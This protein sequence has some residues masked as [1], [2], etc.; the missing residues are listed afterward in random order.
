MQ[1]P[2]HT[3]LLTNEQHTVIDGGIWRWISLALALGWIATTLLL[4]RNRRRTASEQTIQRPKSAPLQPLKKAVSAACASGDAHRTKNALLDWARA[5]W[6][7][8]AVTSLSD[9]AALTG[10]PLAREVHK[11]NDA[12]YSREADWSPDALRS[13]IDGLPAKSGPHRQEDAPVLEPLYRT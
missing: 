6:P 7:D 5:R 11:L 2:K 9:I 1:Q 3:Q 10:E 12:L 13:A 8:E 4:L